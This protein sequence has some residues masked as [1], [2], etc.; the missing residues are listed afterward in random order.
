MNPRRPTSVVPDS[1][2]ETMTVGFLCGLHISENGRALC[3]LLR[4]LDLALD[5]EIDQLVLVGHSMGG[6]VIRSAGHY[7]FF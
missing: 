2:N 1:K 6:L 3:A 7:G 4:D 5:G